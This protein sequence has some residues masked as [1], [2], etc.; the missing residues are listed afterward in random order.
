MRHWGNQ[1]DALAIEAYLRAGGTL[2]AIQPP[3]PG[4]LVEHGEH[5]VA[6]LTGL[7]FHRY[8]ALPK[9]P[10]PSG[11]L[12]LIVGSPAF[13]LGYAATS[14]IVRRRQ[15][16]KWLRTTAPQWR[17]SRLRRVV[18]T[19]RRLWCELPTPTGPQWL[20]FDYDTITRL[21]LRNDGLIL[22]FLQAEPL[23]L[24]GGPWA[25]WCATVVAHHRFGAAAPAA[26]PRLEAEP[27]A[28]AA[29]QS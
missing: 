6:S 7:A 20:R 12:N 28:L 22:H 11:G 24:T 23:R 26:V 16:K 17:Q 19:T 25:P 13:L 3:V 8:T 15:R 14:V 1:A 10:Q 5:A 4:L 18:V 21:E 29:S 27:L 2:P 9:P